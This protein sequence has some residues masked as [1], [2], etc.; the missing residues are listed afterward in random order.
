MFLSPKKHFIPFRTHRRC[1]VLTFGFPVVV[2]KT[3]NYKYVPF[4]PEQQIKLYAP[5]VALYT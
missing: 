1:V 2:P 4:V 3:K 5:V